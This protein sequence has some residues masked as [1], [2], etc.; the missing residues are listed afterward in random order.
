[1]GREEGLGRS[2]DTHSLSPAKSRLPLLPPREL[3]SRTSLEGQAGV[4]DTLPPWEGATMQGVAG[5]K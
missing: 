5:T 2:G 1:M 4:G 3:S